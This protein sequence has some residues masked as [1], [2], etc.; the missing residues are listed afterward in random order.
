MILTLARTAPLLP[1]AVEEKSVQL[2]GDQIPFMV[3]KVR[4][5]AVTFSSFPKTH[6]RGNGGNLIK[7]QH[8]KDGFFVTNSTEI[9]S[10][11]FKNS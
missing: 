5:R 11:H 4:L 1:S 9:C 7:R 3:Q 8:G 10:D 2:L 6:R